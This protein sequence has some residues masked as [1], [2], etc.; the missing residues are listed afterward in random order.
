MKTF[1]KAFLDE[2]DHLEKSKPS[3]YDVYVPCQYWAIIF[4]IMISKYVVEWT[5][6]I[7]VLWFF[8][9]LFSLSLILFMTLNAFVPQIHTKLYS[10]LVRRTAKKDSFYSFFYKKKFFQQQH[11]ASMTK[12]EFSCFIIHNI[13]HTTLIHSKKF[14]IHAKLIWFPKDSIT[15]SIQ[16]IFFPLFLF[17][18]PPISFTLQFT[19]FALRNFLNRKEGN[20]C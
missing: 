1:L 17:E 7:I 10:M 5:F 20:F 11:W 4:T 15:I 9:K 19:H 8:I 6:H 13:R 14:D 2:N 18:N 16:I 12:R 3:G